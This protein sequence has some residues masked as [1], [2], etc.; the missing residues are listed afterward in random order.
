MKSPKFEDSKTRSQF[1]AP[2]PSAPQ[3]LA[4]LQSERASNKAR[5]K[6][7]KDCHNRNKVGQGSSKGSTPTTRVNMVKSR[8]QSQ[9][10]KNNQ[11][12]L[13]RDL[14]NIMCYNCN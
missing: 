7:K 4:L 9:K 6:K 14:N 11:K 2:Q 13:D 10:K 1:S 12:G 3:P 5:R 8:T